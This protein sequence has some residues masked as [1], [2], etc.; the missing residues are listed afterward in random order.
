MNHETHATPESSYESM[1][2]SVDESIAWDDEWIRSW[3]DS[4]E[5]GD[6]DDK[7]DEIH[8]FFAMVS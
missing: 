3:A 4:G 7:E 5:S 6:A 2:A 8:V 1:F